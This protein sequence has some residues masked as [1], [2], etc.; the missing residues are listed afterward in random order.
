MPTA[1]FITPTGV[2]F[3]GSTALSQA[4]NIR[5]SLKK[6]SVS[7]KMP[8]AHEKRLSAKLYRVLVRKSSFV[9]TLFEKKGLKQIA[10]N[11]F[12]LPKNFSEK[13]KRDAGHRATLRVGL[14]VR[15]P[16]QIILQNSLT[17]QKE[18]PSRTHIVREEFLFKLQYY[19][20]IIL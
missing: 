15:P 1:V 3:S 12:H 8:R 14:D 20:Y 19:I 10:Y 18:N 11:L 17:I 2:C 4:E 9:E 7:L 5:V 13:E 6:L 16:L